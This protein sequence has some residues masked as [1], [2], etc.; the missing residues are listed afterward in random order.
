MQKIALSVSGGSD[1][2]SASG[3]IPTGGLD[4]LMSIVGTGLNYLFIAA[5]VIC[6]IVLIWSG[7]SWI[8]SEGDKQRLQKVR[9]RIIFAIVGL[10]IVLA[11]FMIVSFVNNFFGIGISASD[12]GCGVARPGL[13]PRPC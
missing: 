11:S 2:I 12:P 7:I 3:G 9:T 1:S 13:P 6:L 4:K 8:M 10:V 5:I